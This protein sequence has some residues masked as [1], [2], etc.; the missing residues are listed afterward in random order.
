MLP[1]GDQQDYLNENKFQ[2]HQRL[3]RCWLVHFNIKSVSI[4]K[5]LSSRKSSVKTQNQNHSSLASVPAR[6]ESSRPCAGIRADATTSPH[7]APQ[8]SRL[9]AVGTAAHGPENHRRARGFAELTLQVWLT[10]QNRNP[11]DPHW[12]KCPQNLRFF[13]KN[14]VLYCVEFSDKSLKT[15][16][17]T[18]DAK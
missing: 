12:S 1:S 5:K 9:P 18:L 14:Q 8:H 15:R 4:T 2:R 11:P 13:L 3:L 17:R 16:L 7:S 6:G 10:K